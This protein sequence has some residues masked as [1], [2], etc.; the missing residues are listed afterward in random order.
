[1]SFMSLAR[2]RTLR[3]AL[4]EEN[5]DMSELAEID[6]A[7]KELVDSGFELRD[8]PENALATDQLDE[9]EEAVSPLERELF[10]YISENYGENEAMDPCY[11]MGGM[12]NFIESKFEVKEKANA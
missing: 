8:E 5:I 7:F 3:E 2:I 11:N 10:D 6:A 12:V 4:E 1:M 9:L